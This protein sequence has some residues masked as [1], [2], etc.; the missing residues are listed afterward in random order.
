M[1]T[2]TLK[3]VIQFRR[4]TTA[5]WELYKDLVPAAGEPCYD[6]ELGTLK[7]GDGIKSYGELTAIG[8]N[9]S[10]AISADGKSI[11]LEDGVFK[12]AGFD[13]AE[14]GAQPR[15]KS[16]GTIE[17]IVPST[18]T[19]DGL[20]SA[21]AGLQSDVTTLQT[22]VKTI[23]EMVAPSGAATL[24]SRVK[25]LENKI[26]GTGEGTIDAKI[27]AK[28]NEFA[29][30]VTD[31]G[32]V[33]TIQELVTYVANH[34]SEAADMA[35]DI[36]SL[37]GLVGLTSVAD[38]IAAAGHMTK[39]EADATLLSKVE[40]TETLKHVKYEITSV[41]AGTLV[42][43]RDKEIRVMCPTDT[44]WVNQ[45]VGATGNANM[46]YMGFKAY[47]PKG[48][49]SFKEG[50]RGVIIDEMFTFDDEFA[51]TDK[52]GRNY[53]I[54]WLALASYD[55][56]SKSWTYFGKN[57]STRKYIGWDY[58][59][60]W[61]DADG[62]K[63]G[64][65]CIRINLSNESCHHVIEPYYMSKYIKGV[66]VGNTLL[67]VV[68][69]VA[70]IPVGAGLKGSKEIVI[71]EDGTLG[72]GVITWDKIGQGEGELILDGGGAAV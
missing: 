20:Q 6:I 68:D 67:D 28:I 54:C 58:V 52:Y 56:E 18:E 7:I 45:T 41:P 40:A 12:L 50:D 24:P 13:A 51:G 44:Q 4:D 8:G 61:Y 47:A 31:D 69:G 26:D 71:N 72:L 23:Q 70:Q 36:L 21:V 15:K 35:A 2:Q 33:N 22:N 34:G 1:A 48:A 17:W 29:N 27:N 64:S 60:E 14:V 30:R 38:Q 37:Q 42:D 55:S 10:V 62:V 46:Y 57:S 53:S 49:V 3:M 43:Y 66:G 63:I 16:D 5:N 59:V 39:D 65:D 25:A 11:V 9:G 32:T 19:V